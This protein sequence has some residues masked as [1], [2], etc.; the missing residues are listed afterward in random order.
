M[1][2]AAS[3]IGTRAWIKVNDV[4]DYSYADIREPPEMTKNPPVTPSIFPSKLG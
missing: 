4:V 3:Y 2:S 1:I